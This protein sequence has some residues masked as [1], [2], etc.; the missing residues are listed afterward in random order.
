MTTSYQDFVRGVLACESIEEERALIGNEQAKMRTLVKEGDDKYTMRTVAKLM[1]LAMRGENTSYGHMEV[2]KLMASD[3]FSYKRMGYLAAMVLLDE[4]PELMVLMIETVRKDLAGPFKG[5]AF[6]LIANIGNAE[7]SESLSEDV[8]NAGRQATGLAKGRYMAMYTMMKRNK[9]LVQRVNSAMNDWWSDGAVLPALHLACLALKLEPE[10]W[11][12]ERKESSSEKFTKNLVELIGRYAS[13]AYE[14]NGVSDPFLQIMMLRF[15][16]ALKVSSHQ[17]DDVLSRIC[18]NVDLRTNTGRAI[19][20][21]CVQ[22]IGQV[23]K[24]P[25]LKSLAF[26]QIGRLLGSS[27]Q[28]NVIYSALSAFSRILYSHNEMLDRT[29]GDSMVLQRY[30]SDVVQCLSHQDPS[31]RRRALDVVAALVDET[32]V[33]SLIP[34]VMSYL[35]MADRDFKAEIVAKVFAAVQRF[36]PTILWNYDTILKLITD[37]GS[38]VGSDVIVAFCRLIAR[39]VDI[40]THALVTLS[41]AL[42]TNNENQT[43]LQVSAW[44]L[45]EFLDDPTDVIDSMMKLMH[46]P[47]TV[48]ETKLVVITALCKIAIRLNIIEKVKEHLQ[49]FFSNN[50][51]EVQQRV[52]EMLR[53]LDK[54]EIRDSLLAP[55]EVDQVEGAT[56][57]PNPEQDEVDLLGLGEPTPAQQPSTHTDLITQLQQAEAQAP[58]PQPA[59]APQ[60]PAVAGPPGSVEALRTPDYVIFFEIQRNAANPRQMAIRSTIFNLGNVPLTNFIVQYGIPQG[61]VVKAQPPSSSVLEAVGGKP[62]QQVM[63]LENGGN[64]PLRMMTQIS[65]MYRTQPIKERNEINPIFNT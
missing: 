24:E 33:E 57:K 29:P 16:A 52:G 65:Y 26:N 27:K 11:S 44:A 49:L 40:R 15:L 54:P 9:D 32:N 2:L 4:S 34:E 21:E 59:Q 42:K 13:E 1:Y 53:V 63:M 7:M 31:I 35:K 41:D 55:I 36:A 56:S 37:S 60:A 38:Y 17:L 6:Y 48:V 23:A 39:Y 28:A 18:T 12:E 61:W 20:L 19:L 5:L 51:L 47:Q 64:A 3:R 46:L 22:T 30:K 62:I 58:P 8:L 25:Q 10:I 43:L 45:G 50:N 14:F